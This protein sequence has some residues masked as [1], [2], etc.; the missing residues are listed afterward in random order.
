MQYIYLMYV[1]W[2]IWK[3]RYCQQLTHRVGLRS[4]I[5]WRPPGYIAREHRLFG[6]A[7][8][9][10]A[11]DPAAELSH[12]R[13]NQENIIKTARSSVNHPRCRSVFHTGQWAPR[14][15][16]TART[17]FWSVRY[18]F[19]FSAERR[20][21]GT[22]RWQRLR[23]TGSKNADHGPLSSGL[24]QHIKKCQIEIDLLNFLQW[25]MFLK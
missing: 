11:I 3:S 16:A 17:T 18:W 4:L 23:Q 21:V 12:T 13:E 14:R 10:G 25:K 24:I 5:S 6:R 19:R 2:K 15:A 8:G 22:G 20:D 7:L 1:H 9:G